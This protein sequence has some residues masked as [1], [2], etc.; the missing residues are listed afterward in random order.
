MC[1]EP[2]LGA[3]AADDGKSHTEGAVPPFLPTTHPDVAAH[4]H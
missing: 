1:P 2:F 3:Q 4:G